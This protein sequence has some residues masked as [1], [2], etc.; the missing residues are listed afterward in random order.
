MMDDE[1][2]TVSQ[3][4]LLDASPAPP[5][6]CVQRIVGA[7]PDFVT[8]ASWLETIPVALRRGPP[9]PA[10]FVFITL[11]VA[12]LAA[13]GAP[14]ASSFASSA[15]FPRDP[16]WLVAWRGVFGAIGAAILAACVAYS[17]W[18]FVTFTMQSFAW[19][20]LRLLLAAIAS[21]SPTADALAPARAIA[22]TIRFPALAQT[23]LTVVLWWLVLTPLITYQL[24][25]TPG[26]A[27]FRRFNFSPF[28]LTVHL[29]NL[30]VAAVEFV[31][32]EVS[33]R[34]FDLWISLVFALVYLCFYLYVLDRNDVHLYI[35]LTPRTAACFLVYS[36]IIG[37]F[38]AAYCGWNA[39]LS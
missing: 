20:T 12:A 8:K 3:V 16:A 11:A 4:G 26:A 28:L 2:V 1:K 32:S 35:I 31:A 19:L 39:A 21:A 15:E 29:F 30:P 36:L 22:A 18:V 17:P 23:T 5:R 27:D 13:M 33:L 7:V 10:V 14:A 25:G 6:G 24:R 38:V 9:S 34:P 37:L